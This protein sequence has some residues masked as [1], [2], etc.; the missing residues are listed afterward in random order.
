MLAF[1]PPGQCDAQSSQYPRPPQ[2]GAGAN[3]FVINDKTDNG[4]KKRE[5]P[6][7]A[8]AMPFLVII[9]DGQHNRIN[10]QYQD[11]QPVGHVSAG[12]CI[13]IGILG[14]SI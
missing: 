1:V 4:D 2:I 3:V 14:I 9:V 11:Y 8:G 6:P 7:A 12:F 10:Y 13:F 5:E